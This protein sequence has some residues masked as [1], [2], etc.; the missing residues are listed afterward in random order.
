MDLRR[1]LGDEPVMAS[2]PSRAYLLRKFIR[3][4]RGPVL[5]VSLVLLAL[6]GGVI[7]TTW[8]LIRTEHARRKAVAAELAHANLARTERR[9]KEE[10][11]KRLAQIEMGTTTLASIIRDID[12][13]VADNQGVTLRALLGRRLSEAARQLEGEAMGDPLIVARLQHVLGVALRESG[14]SCQ[15]EAVLAKA[16][17]TRE[18]LLGADNL[19]TATTQHQLAMLYRDQAKYDLAEKLYGEAL[20]SRTSKLGIDHPDTLDSQHHLAMLHYAKREYDLAEAMLREVVELRTGRLGAD[21]PDTLTSQHRLAWLY[22]SQWKYAAAETLCREVLR[23][24]AASLGNNHL[25]AIAS[26]QLLAVLC[27][28]QHKP[29]LAEPLFKEVLEVRTTK[30]GAD[31]PDTLT[32]QYH[33]AMLY[34]SVGKLDRS[35]PMLEDTLKLRKAKLDPDHPAT[36]S[37]QV[38]LGSTYCNVGR[39]TEGIALLEELHQKGHTAGE[40]ARVGTALLQAYL[41][42]G[43]RTEAKA[44]ATE[45]LQAAHDKYPADSLRHFG[46]LVDAGWMFVE[47]KSYHEAELLLREALF[48]GDHY[49]P[50]FWRTHHAR[51]LLGV[52]LLGQEKVTQAEPVL[53]AGYAG[54]QLRAAQIPPD[55]GFPLTQAVQ[56]VDELYE[57]LEQPYQAAEW[58]TRLKVRTES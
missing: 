57:A 56:W 38:D 30:L 9:A 20:A 37:T 26:K 25:D 49:F 21:H 46:M 22:R 51:L 27:F 44:L 13:L 53:L 36:L 31:H 52:A 3:R 42:A 50:D 34:S 48:R 41:H 55:P 40:L 39:V 35:I 7:G 18:R 5:S 33:L 8:G 58:R 14:H 43:R 28:S 19:E 2:P 12:P 32:T 47:E 29:E 45:L 15:A 10:A 16:C 4:N 54:T 11:Q 6:V 24:R 17:Q 1:Y 23:R